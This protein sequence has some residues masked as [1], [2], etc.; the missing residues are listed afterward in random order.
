M[1]YGAS[2]MHIYDPSKIHPST[3]FV[4]SHSPSPFSI[5]TSDIGNGLPSLANEGVIR[6]CEYHG[7]VCVIGVA[8]FS[9]I[10]LADFIKLSI[11]S[12]ITFINM[13]LATF[14]HSFI[15]G[16]WFIPLFGMF[17]CSSGCG[18]SVPTGEFMFC[19]VTFLTV[20]VTFNK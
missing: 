11:N 20:S 8:E 13:S 4:V 16:M 7:G 10:Y 6:L 18:V 19:S 14:F 15:F 1:F 17:Y 9:L 5:F 3:S 2:S 12:S